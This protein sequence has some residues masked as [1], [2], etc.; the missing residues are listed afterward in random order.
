MEVACLCSI[1]VGGDKR[2][3]HHL[4]GIFITLG[5]GYIDRSITRFIIDGR[6][7][8]RGIIKA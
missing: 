1:T 8:K 2:Q 3:M 4:L 5:Q 7:I 6:T